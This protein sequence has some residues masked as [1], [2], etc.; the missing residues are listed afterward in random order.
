[1]GCKISCFLIAA[2]TGQLIS[3]RA[4]VLGGELYSFHELYV[5]DKKKTWRVLKNFCPLVRFSRT[6]LKWKTVCVGSLLQGAN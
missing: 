6:W 5:K 3:F 1:M 2:Q 4:I